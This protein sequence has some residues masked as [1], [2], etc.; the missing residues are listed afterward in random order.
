MVLRRCHGRRSRCRHVHRRVLR[1]CRVRNRPFPCRR[2]REV[3]SQFYLVEVCR[4]PVVFH[5][6]STCQMK[7]K[8]LRRRLED[9]CR[10]SGA[11]CELC[12]G[13]VD[14]FAFGKLL[15]TCPGPH[16]FFA[17][18]RSNTPPV[19][20]RSNTRS[21][22]TRAAEAANTPTRHKHPP[23]LH[24]PS[25][26]TTQPTRRHSPRRRAPHSIPPHPHLFLWRVLRLLHHDL[27]L[28]PLEQR[29]HVAKGSLGSRDHE[30]RQE[31]G[32]R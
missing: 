28:R 11:M 27:V 16:T 29:E 13:A 30:E 23:S 32:E 19:R 5:S 14:V 31:E 2:D 8:A 15:R 7:V 21:S 6:L 12:V 1:P 3:R 24:A 10:R 22:H 17:N 25:S 9:G 18:N 4:W 26:P 20:R